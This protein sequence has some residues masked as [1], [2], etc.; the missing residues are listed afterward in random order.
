MLP[1]GKL[2]TIWYPFHTYFLKY[3]TACNILLPKPSLFQIQQTQNI[4]CFFLWYDSGPFFNLLIWLCLIFLFCLHLLNYCS[5]TQV[6]RSW[7]V[8]GFY[9]QQNFWSYSLTSVRLLSLSN[10][11]QNLMWF[12]TRCNEYCES[13]H[14]LTLNIIFLSSTNSKTS[15]YP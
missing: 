10:Y 3:L 11:H 7:E 1:H 6:Q 4:W 14:V 5:L 8:A 15:I 9:T 13:F 12:I 2:R